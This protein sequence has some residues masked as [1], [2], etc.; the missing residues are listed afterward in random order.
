MAQSGLTEKLLDLDAEIYHFHDPELL[1]LAARLKRKSGKAVIYDKHESY[2]DRRGVQKIAMQLERRYL[3][4]MDRV[5]IAEASYR[6]DLVDV[7]TK[8]VDL[9]NY[10]KPGINFPHPQNPNLAEGEKLKLLYTGFVARQRG[11]DVMLRLAEDLREEGVDF[12]LTIAGLCQ[13]AKDRIWG[14]TE[15][16]KKGLSTNVKRVGWTHFVD[17][18]TME[19]LLSGHHIGLCLLDPLPNYQKS[20]PTKFYEYAHFGLPV[21]CSDF[22][23]WQN[24]LQENKCGQAVSGRKE[25]KKLLGIIRTMSEVQR[26]SELSLAAN[27]SVNKYSWETMERNLLETYTELLS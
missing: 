19:T 13:I 10:Y 15:I 25:P 2:L 12:E 7:D 22:P 17:H 5:M 21:I 23:L 1:P 3:P 9:F 4:A 20:I 11:L 24:Y 16:E 8:L 14:D 18:Q 6:E 27:Q 26:F